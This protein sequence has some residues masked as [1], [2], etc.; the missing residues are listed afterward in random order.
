MGN[1]AEMIGYHRL[2]NGQADLK[3]TVCVYLNVS[4]RPEQAG[5]H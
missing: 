4:A 3:Q 2:F 5:A 1:K